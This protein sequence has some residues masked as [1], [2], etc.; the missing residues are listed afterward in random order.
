MAHKVFSIP[1]NCV[2]IAGRNFYRN[3]SYATLNLLGLA[4]GFAAFILAA[5]YVYFETHFESFHHKADRIYRAT[6]RYSPP[7]DFQSHWARVPFDYI[8]ELP[9]EIAGVKTLIRFQ[10]HAR[11]YVRIGEHKFTPANTY[12]TDAEVFDV[13]DFRLIAGNPNRALAEPHSVVISESLATKYFGDQ[14]PLGKEMYVIG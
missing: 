9:K 11:K 5:T 12:V 1:A 13:F 6:Y 14:N 2:K 7:G 3:R 10:N 4:V 8:N